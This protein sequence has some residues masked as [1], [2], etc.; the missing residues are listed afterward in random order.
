MAYPR[1]ARVTLMMAVMLVATGLFLLFK[2]TPHEPADSSTRPENKRAT[3]I[4]R[5]HDRPADE[6]TLPDPSVTDLIQSAWEEFRTGLN[7]AQAADLLRTLREG[8]R[9][10]P[11]DEAAAAIL[12][13]LKSR[14]DAA[15]G[16]PFT[17]GPEGMMG[18]AP[19]LRLALLDLLPSL[20]PMASLELAR[21]IMQQRTSPDEYAISLRNMAWNDLDGDLRD[22][23]S[24]RFMDLLDTPWLDEPSPGFLEAFDIS[25]EVGGSAMFDRMASL[26][27]EAMEKS[28]PMASQAAFMSMD[29]M[30]VRDPAL[31]TSALA[32]DPAWMDF[33]PQQRASLASRLDITDPAQK[34]L[35]TRYLSSA[36]APG[37]LEYFSKLFPN[38]NYLHGHRLV[39]GDETTP[40][41]TEVAASDAR[42][43]RELDTLEAG[44][45]AEAAI[46][47]IRERLV[48]AG[49]SR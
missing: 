40:S 16:L 30:V 41:I 2:P 31:L 43:L 18:T 10:A 8:I 34:E 39:T 38:Q 23:L 32:Q 22:E 48:K 47:T 13:F 33:A 11:E 21:A 14:D 45:P 46:R 15:T 37:E 26:A 12:G 7:P 19:T 25:V 49:T 24:G 9:Q 20:D 28:N 6:A 36:H 44:T 17:V 4:N 27:R 5:D 35:F 29:R 42:V 1:S 3:S